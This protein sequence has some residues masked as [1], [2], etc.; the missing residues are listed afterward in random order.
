MLKSRE[1]LLLMI[2]CFTDTET[3]EFDTDCHV[4]ALHD[5]LPIARA[6]APGPA[7]RAPPRARWPRPRA[8]ERVLQEGAAARLR[9]ARSEEHTSELQSLMRNAY[10]VFC[11]TKK[12]LNK[13]KQYTDT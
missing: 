4:L 13:N 7:R 2:F 5:A 6:A 10:A 3:P 1:F 8:G 11:L 12:I 9:R